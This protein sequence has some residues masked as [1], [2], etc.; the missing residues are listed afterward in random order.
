[1]NEMSYAVMGHRG[2]N[3]FGVHWDG[4]RGHTLLSVHRM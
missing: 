3:A 2:I 1:M 4:V